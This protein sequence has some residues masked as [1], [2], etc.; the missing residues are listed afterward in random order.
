MKAV[1]TTAELYAMGRHLAYPA[2]YT[3]DKKP[4]TWR[5]TE[6]GHALLGR[7]MAENAAE[8]VAAGRGTWQRPPNSGK[9]LAH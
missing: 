9:V 6:E 2:S 8:A 3:A 5:I 4:S 7:I 1:P